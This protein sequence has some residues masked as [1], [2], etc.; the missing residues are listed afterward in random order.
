MAEI[1]SLKTLAKA[2]A[3]AND[4]LLVTNTS[5]NIATKYALTNVFPSL[6]NYG[7]SEGLFVDVTGKN[8]LR[9]K[10]IK[11]GDASKVT[12]TTVSRDLVVSLVEAGIDLNNCNN[13]AAE[14]TKGVDFNKTVLGANLVANG[15]TGVTSIAK[16]SILYASDTDTLA[17]AD[18]TSNGAII[19]GNA[20]TRV[21]SIT[22]LTAGANITITNGPGS[23]TITASLT[24]LA[25]NLDCSTFGV[26]LNHSAG[27]SWVSGDG[28]AE[29]IS[30]DA[31][32]KV[33]I[34]D[35][36]PTLPTI[37][38]Q[39]HIAGAS[40]T[41]IAI[42]N[43]NN[44]KDHTLLALSAPSGV[45][46]L[47]FT[48]QGASA[49]GGNAAGGNVLVRAGAGHGSGSGGY[50]DLYGGTS[51]SGLVGGVRM[52][53]NPS[54]TPIVS[55]ELNRLNDFTLNY[56]NAVIASATKGLV[57]TG[58]GVVT[59]ATDYSTAVTLNATSGV[60]TLA[61]VAL[62]V[63]G[64][65]EFVFTNSSIRSTSVIMLTMQDENTT[66]NA[67]LAVAINSVVDGSCKISIQNPAATGTSSATASKVHF[68]IINTT[69]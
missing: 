21:P 26:N 7:T 35:S 12:V 48:I 36:V 54:G 60:I 11:S 66:N 38:G 53:T 24:A 55:A 4:V 33:F 62:A 46:G 3:T 64:N 44:Y 5:T 34:G 61:A 50:V 8:Q 40:T 13:T 63:A 10:S 69:L 18:V 68:L 37:A 19:V 29:G 32:G 43:T 16:G 28:T 65:E 45:A 15:G 27:R 2:S 31:E 58:S 30:V 17:S 14:F 39:L 20:S 42:G 6:L 23:I 52:Y 59:Q 56:G 9:F 49:T 57:H 22:T 25:A 41:A 47:N 51:T 1:K 67:Q